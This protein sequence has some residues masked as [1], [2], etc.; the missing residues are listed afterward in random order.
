MYRPANSSDEPSRV[1][2]WRHLM[3]PSS[4][5]RRGVI[6]VLAAILMIVMMGMLAFSIDVGYMYTMQSQLQ[7]SVDS[8][9]LAGAGAL[10]DGEEAALDSVHE[11]LVRNPVGTQWQIYDNQAIESDIDHFKTNYGSGLNVNIGQWDTA[12]QQVVVS[13]HNPSTV[14]V[15][16]TYRNMPFFF[17]HLLGRGHFDIT[18][19]SV[20]AF[21]PRD[22]VL[23]LDLSGSMNDD[24]EFVSINKLGRSTVENNL[25][26]IYGELGSPTYGNL[27]FAPEFAVVPGVSPQSSNQ[28]NVTVEYRFNQVFV[29][30]NKTLKNVRLKLSNGNEVSYNP[31]GLTATLSPGREIRY[32]W[33]N[34]GKN[35]NN[36]DQVQTF[37][38]ESNQINNTIRKAL[39]LDDVAY[40][41]PSGSWNEYINYVRSSSGQNNSAG[42]RHKY[43]AM[44]LINFW[45]QNKPGYNQTPDLWKVSA[46]PITALKNS[47]D[48]FIHFLEEVDC[49]DRLGLA[50]YNAPNGNGLLESTLT[51]NF[52]FVK[53][54]TNRKQASHYHNYTNIGAGM[55][56]ARE[57]LDA[58]GRPGA[59]KMIVLMT[60]GVANY[61]NG[62][63]NA[64]AA[65]NYVLSEAHLAAAS[66]YPIVTIS[67]GAGADV[68]LMEEVAEI[69]KGATFNVPGGRPAE[70]YAE[71]LAEVFKKIAKH[72]PLKLV[73]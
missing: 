8:A 21:Q 71:D 12:T 68:P 33:V 49:D 69:T 19:E 5:P 11:Y 64:G 24:S 13:E 15:S 58:R 55:T 18:A 30:S 2:V 73:K 63:V 25:N 70:E 48:F 61:I 59:L 14:G 53:D 4:G 28:A 36:S 26:Q 35:A 6:V 29:T 10:V 66:G 52:S 40:P 37:N 47:V 31:G 9:T 3:L 45:L 65:R 20:A 7:R 51:R 17:G 34:S 42:Y 67:L 46:Q 60:D 16:M 56:T 1:T 62:G 50:V 27:Q 39:G 38:F 44:N 72:R 32:V 23:V 54:Q 57:E 22:I 41:Y 43:G